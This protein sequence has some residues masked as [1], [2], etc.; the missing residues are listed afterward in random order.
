MSVAADR[1][2]EDAAEDDGA[3][4]ERPLRRVAA[5]V[6]SLVVAVVVVGAAGAC[7]GDRAVVH[8]EGGGDS[9]RGPELI[10]EYG[11]GSCHSVPG[12]TGANGRVGPSLEGFG[13]QIYIAGELV[14]TPENLVRWITDPQG[15]EPGTAMPDLDVSD[16][17]AR[18]IAAY[19]LSLGR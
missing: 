7:G 4:V 16:E 15:V 1:V 13:Q 6:M 9:R 10:E 18:D 12:V 11:C 14:N 19:L 2:P 8:L 3:T 5:L 17:D